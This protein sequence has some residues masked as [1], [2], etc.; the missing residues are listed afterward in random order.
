MSG[1]S[2]ILQNTSSLKNVHSFQQKFTAKVLYMHV[3]T[4]LH[5]ECWQ[6]LFKNPSSPPS[7]SI[8]LELRL[9]DSYF[10]MQR[11]L[12]TLCQAR[13]SKSTRNVQF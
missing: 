8:Q 11:K 7:Y 2:L 1:E 10:N 6:T 3:I 13:H 12:T 5:W 9:L 4:H